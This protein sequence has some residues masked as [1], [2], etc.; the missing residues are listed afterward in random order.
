MLKARRNFDLL[1]IAERRIL[2]LQKATAPMRA[3]PE[4]ITGKNQDD[5]GKAAEIARFFWPRFVELW[6]FASIAIFFLLRVL[7]SHAAQRFLNGIG[8][9][10]LS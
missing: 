1:A 6:I 5:G 9:H 7:G 4:S 10:H 3:S 2:T 8:R